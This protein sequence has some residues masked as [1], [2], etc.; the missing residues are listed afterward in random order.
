MRFENGRNSATA[1][2]S[3]KGRRSG[4]VDRRGL[5]K[6]SRGR[7]E[8]SLGNMMAVRS[9]MKDKV[10]IQLR[11]R[12]HSLPELFHQSGS[13][14]SDFL[15]RELHLV[16]E[17]HAAAQIQRGCH[18]RLFHRERHRTV[19]RQTMFVAGGL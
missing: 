15:G 14:L 4:G 6:R 11:I 8:Q 1:S 16:D 12:G 3:T 17:L 10:Q 18:Q 13:E 9:V 5:A 2:P 19:T 7:L